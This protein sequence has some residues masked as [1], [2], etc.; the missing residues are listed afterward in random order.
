MLD[1]HVCWFLNLMHRPC[2]WC[3]LLWCLLFDSQWTLFQLYLGVRLRK[4]N[5]LRPTNPKV[6]GCYLITSLHWTSILDRS[7]DWWGPKNKHHKRH[8]FE[9]DWTMSS[10]FINTSTLRSEHDW[11]DLCIQLRNEQTLLQAYGSKTFDLCQWKIVLCNYNFCKSS[12][13]IVLSSMWSDCVGLI[14]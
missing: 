7:V 3:P 12:I 1:V 10:K 13:N 9:R 6:C 4:T 14:C 2:R 8:V 5:Q 11:G